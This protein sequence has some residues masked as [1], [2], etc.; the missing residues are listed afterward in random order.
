MHTATQQIVS[1]LS[2]RTFDELAKEYIAIMKEQ[3]RSESHAEAMRYSLEVCAAPLAHKY[4]DAITPDDVL[5][6]VRKARQPYRTLQAINRVFCFAISEDH[7]LDNPAAHPKLKFRFPASRAEHHHAAMDYNEVPAF[8]Q[9]LRTEEHVLSARVLQYLILTACRE[10]EVAGMMWSEI[11]LE[12]KVWHCPIAD[13]RAKTGH[14]HRVPLSPRAME[15]VGPNGPK[16]VHRQIGNGVA[17][18]TVGKT[19]PQILFV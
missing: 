1:A 8:M 5:A 2:S 18:F 14:I 6:T 16:S 13:G 11:N 7:R 9:R 17:N 3:W 4:V 10:G 19:D 12:T 15:L